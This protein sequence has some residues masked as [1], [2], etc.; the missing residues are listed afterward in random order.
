MLCVS[1]DIHA[2]QIEPDPLPL[3]IPLPRRSLVTRPGEEGLGEG[4]PTIA[5]RHRSTPRFDDN[6]FSSQ[7]SP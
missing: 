7:N 1:L 5:Y 4:F 6:I 2:K 3:L